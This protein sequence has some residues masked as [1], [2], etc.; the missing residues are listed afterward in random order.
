MQSGSA[1]TIASRAVKSISFR[2]VASHELSS[3]FEAFRLMCN[4]A[5]GIATKE[6]PR[7]RFNLSELAYSRLKHHGL[8]THY[9]LSAIEIAYSVYRNKKRKRVPYIK[10][11][12]LKLDNQSYQLNHLL[13][14]IPT[15]PR[16]FVFLTLKG[17]DY[18][19]TFV[20]DP[21]LKRGSVTISERSVCI[22]FT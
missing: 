17:S 21:N 4:E 16:N 6:K 20:D 2:Y 15:T 14:R 19:L 8:H 3:L 1:S 22:S 7:N 10:R 9:V 13:L 11:G 5:I 18:H 12:F